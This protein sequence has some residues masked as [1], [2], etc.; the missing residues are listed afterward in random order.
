MK[1]RWYDWWPW[2]AWRVIGSVDAADEIPEHLP[3]TAIVVVG[4]M[5]SPKWIAFDC[6]CRE[7]HRVLLPAA[8]TA[9]PRWSLVG[10]QRTTLS[11]SIDAWHTATQR[12]HYF[13]RQG[14]VEWVRHPTP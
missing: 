7:G 10:Q 1:I 11:P 2:Q 5:E 9:S 3:R 13:I 8:R 6:P 12:C 4:P 14:H